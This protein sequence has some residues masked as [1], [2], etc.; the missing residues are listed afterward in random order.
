MLIG[1]WCF[2]V[3]TWKKQSLT[4]PT[5]S[6]SSSVLCSFIDSVYNRMFDIFNFL[7]KKITNQHYLGWCKSCGV[8]SC[9]E[10]SSSF[11]TLV[12]VAWGLYDQRSPYWCILAYFRCLDHMNNGSV[13]CRTIHFVCWTENCF[14]LGLLVNTLAYQQSVHT[15]HHF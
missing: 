15:V 8:C 11:G 7:H 1:K 3:E 6:L 4:M 9:C 13:E 2:A 10:A 12:D 5:F 14:G